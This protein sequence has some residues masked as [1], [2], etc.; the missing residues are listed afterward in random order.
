M[1]HRCIRPQLYRHH[2]TCRCTCRH[3]TS[4]FIDLLY[5]SNH[6]LTLTLTPSARSRQTRT[7]C[8]PRLLRL[9]PVPCVHYDLRAT[10]INRLNACMNFRWFSSL[11]DTMPPHPALL[12]SWLLLSPGVDA[13]RRLVPQPLGVADGQVH[14]LVVSPHV[15]LSALAPPLLDELL[16][17]RQARRRR[18]PVTTAALSPPRLRCSR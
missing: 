18:H 12:E 3:A 10:P 16:R 11:I 7:Y 2:A 4:I 8:P 1:K 5:L 14:V 6:P 17:R 15:Q 9:P 13:T